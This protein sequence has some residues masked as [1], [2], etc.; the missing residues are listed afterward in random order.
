MVGLIEIQYLK[1]ERRLLRQP[2]TAN[3]LHPKFTK[4]KIFEK[5]WSLYSNS[6]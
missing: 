3:G 1:D 4:H 5:R 6:R 2:P